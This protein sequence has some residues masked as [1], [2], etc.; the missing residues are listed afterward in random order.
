MSR[1]PL[2]NIAELIIDPDFCQDFKVT[3][4]TGSWS[5][6]RFVTEDSEL[7]C[8]GIIDPH[9]TEEMQFNPDGV[10]IRGLIKVY[11]HMNL[12]T[13]HKSPSEV[14]TEGYISDLVVWQGK[15]YIVLN[16]DN[17]SDYG[18]HGYTCQLEEATGGSSN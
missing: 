16:E 8:Y 2:L 17:Y 15:N 1:T 6:G 18:Y 10:L 11:T 7:D 14:D 13:T 3:R 4:R 5:N 9:T 12:Y